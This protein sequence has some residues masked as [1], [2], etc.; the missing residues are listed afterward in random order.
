M[1][2]LSPKMRAALKQVHPGLTDAEIDRYEALIFERMQCDPETQAKRIAD[3]DDERVTLLKE[4]MPRFNDVAR[5]IASEAP[6]RKQRRAA[7]VT[8]KK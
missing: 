7:T 1:E 5:Q 8:V 6:P 2:P 3:L 4:R